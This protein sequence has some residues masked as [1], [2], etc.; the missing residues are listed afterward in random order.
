MFLF[1]LNNIKRFFKWLLIMVSHIWFECVETHVT[2]WIEY[3][4]SMYLLY[5]L[6]FFYAKYSIFVVLRFV[7]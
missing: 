5:L 4:N 3:Y 2:T 6:Y 1:N 7:L